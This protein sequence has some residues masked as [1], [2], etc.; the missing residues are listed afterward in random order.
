LG[1]FNFTLQTSLFKL[2][3]G[4]RRFSSGKEAA[5]FG[6]LAS[7][8]GEGCWGFLISP[9]KLHSSNFLSA[10]AIFHP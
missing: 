6:I 5:L 3:I 9:F 2:L 10:T 8:F 4:D 1:L 7:N